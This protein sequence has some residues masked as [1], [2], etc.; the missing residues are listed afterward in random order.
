M[1][2]DRFLSFAKSVDRKVVLSF[3]SHFLRFTNSMF[4]SKLAEAKVVRLADKVCMIT[5]AGSGIGRATAVQFTRNGAIV[6]A[7]DLNAS[8]LEKTRRLIEQE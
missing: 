6:V 8:E 7:I 2:F 5:G 3:N 1:F 4:S